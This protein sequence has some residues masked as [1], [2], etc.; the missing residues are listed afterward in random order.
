MT[1]KTWELLTE[2]V[3]YVRLVWYGWKNY[4]GSENTIHTKHEIHISGISKAMSVDSKTSL[5]QSE[6]PAL[7][8]RIDI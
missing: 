7:F 2:Q 3:L 5:Y 4:N 1:L 6:F 8:L